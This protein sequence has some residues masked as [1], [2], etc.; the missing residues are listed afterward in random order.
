MVVQQEI[1]GTTTEQVK[2][3]KGGIIDQIIAKVWEFLYSVFKNNNKT[4]AE[5]IKRH[6]DFIN[7]SDEVLIQQDSPQQ[8]KI[9]INF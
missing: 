8:S 6:I 5:V 9:C 2:Y 1:L 7:K 3:T 4:L